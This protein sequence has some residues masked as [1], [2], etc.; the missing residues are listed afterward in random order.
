M[1]VIRLLDGEEVSA[2][3]GDKLSINRQTGV[4]TVS[5]VEGFQEITTHYSPA[6]WVSVT[7]RVKD[8]VNPA[9]VSPARKAQ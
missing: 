7:H 8:T 4:I 3:D 1:F 2:H 6:A 5:R 9:L